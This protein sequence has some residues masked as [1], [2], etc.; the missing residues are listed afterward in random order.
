MFSSVITHYDFSN[1]LCVVRDEMQRLSC[2]LRKAQIKVDCLIWL[3]ITD[4]DLCI[5][6]DIISSLNYGLIL[7]V[8]QTQ[9]LTSIDLLPSK[10]QQELGT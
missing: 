7:W 8:R 6:W 10:M 9:E 5:N 1:H 4:V 3:S 2:V